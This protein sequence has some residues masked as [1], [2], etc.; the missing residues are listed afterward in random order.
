MN[1]IL[2]YNLAEDSILQDLSIVNEGLDQVEIGL[3]EEA[4]RRFNVS[5]AV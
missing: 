1:V 2:E 4:A 5:Y 3:L